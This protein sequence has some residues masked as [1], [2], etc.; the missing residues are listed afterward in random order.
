MEKREKTK[1]MI[2]I[3]MGVLAGFISGFF[4]AGGGLILV[5]YLSLY[6]KKDE[7]SSRATTIFCIFFMVFVSSL[8]YIK[9]SHA[10]F[11]LSIK[12]IIGGI[13]GSIFGSKLLIKLDKK[14]LNILFIIFLIYSGIRMIV[15]G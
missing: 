13:I 5:T 10:D 1:F 11:I 8:F 14:I 4:G 12:C 2:T 15:G 7:V 3:F 6:L 9:E